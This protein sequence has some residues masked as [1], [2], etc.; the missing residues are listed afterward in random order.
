MSR[1]IIS[2]RMA[3]KS[4]GPQTNTSYSDLCEDNK[5]FVEIASY[6]C[7]GGIIEYVNVR[8]GSSGR[9]FQK[10]PNKTGEANILIICPFWINNPPCFFFFLFFFLF[11][12][13]R[14]LVIFFGR[15]IFKDGS[16]KMWGV[17]ESPLAIFSPSVNFCK[18]IYGAYSNW[19]KNLSLWHVIQEKMKLSINRGISC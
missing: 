19:I 8:T 7:W 12:L 4:A 18:R 16:R 17:C 1:L 9:R 15:S 13:Y 10:W 14:W 6:D 2:K 5:A 11:H 3:L